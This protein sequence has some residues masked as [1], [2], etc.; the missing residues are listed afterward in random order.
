MGWGAGLV[1]LIVNLASF[2]GCASSAAGQQGARQSACD[3]YIGYGCV[4]PTVEMG[5]QLQM[6]PA[7]ASICNWPIHSSL[8]VPER[9][10]GMAADAH[11]VATERSKILTKAM[12]ASTIVGKLVYT[13]KTTQKSVTTAIRETTMIVLRPAVIIQD[14]FFSGATMLSSS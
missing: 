11:A 7:P 14:R 13:S 9:L 1:E 6:L 2:V 5:V 12:P 4:A 10:R 8:S 3:G